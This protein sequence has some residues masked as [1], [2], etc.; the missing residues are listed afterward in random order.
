MAI[1]T[2]SELQES[3]FSG[4]SAVYMVKGGITTAAASATI[5]DSDVVEAPVSED[6]GFT[7]NGGTP[8]ISHFRIHGLQS[9]WA[10]KF[11]PGDGELNLEI[12][13]YDDSVLDLVYGS[14]G[15]ETTL[16]LPTGITVGGKS[17]VKGNARSFEQKAVYLGL[18]VLN[19]TADRLLFIKKAKFIA[20]PAFD[21][22]DKP[23]AITLT[24]ALSASTDADAYGIFA[25]VT[26]G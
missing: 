10:S 15:T 12:P 5:N 14:S 8:S 1:K 20:T 3:V 7:F 2:K 6:S 25:P 16:N 9:D 23:Y 19:D 21:G 22:G 17:K 24:G 4:I 26:E 18:L 11:T 13:C